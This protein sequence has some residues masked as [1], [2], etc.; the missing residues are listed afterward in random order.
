MLQER[1]QELSRSTAFGTARLSDVLSHHEIGNPS[2]LFPT[3]ELVKTW[4]HLYC[5]SS[6]WLT[7]ANKL[8]QSFLFNSISLKSCSFSYRFTR[9]GCTI[10]LPL[11][12]TIEESA[13]RRHVWQYWA[14]PGSAR[15]PESVADSSIG[16]RGCEQIMLQGQVGGRNGTLFANTY[17]Q[18]QNS[19]LVFWSLF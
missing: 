12:E 1:G 19:M 18:L 10:C 5:P 7:L 8:F 9:Y 2:A 13:K 6:F 14:K 17:Q 11:R 15:C 16:S 3:M 4:S